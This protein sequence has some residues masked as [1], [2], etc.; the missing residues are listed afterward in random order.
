LTSAADKGIQFTGVGTAGTYDLTTAGKALLD[1]ASASDQLTTLGVSTFAKTILDDTDEATFKATV[2]L[3]IGT[4]VQ[5]YDAQLDTWAGITP[6]A[7]ISTFLTTPSSANLASVT[8]LQ[9]AQMLL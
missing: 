2:N 5:A 1:D 7:G 6:A 9:A 8:M 4:D 3:E